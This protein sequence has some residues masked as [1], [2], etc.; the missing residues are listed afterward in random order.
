MFIEAQDLQLSHPQ[1]TDTD[2]SVFAGDSCIEIEPES[3]VNLEDPSKRRE[4][5]I[6]NDS[7]KQF[8]AYQD[9]K[10]LR[11][12]SDSSSKESKAESGS[13]NTSN[14]GSNYV[15]TSSL[16]S[17]SLEG[18][19]E[20]PA[21]KRKDSAGPSCGNIDADINYEISPESTL[22]KASVDISEYPTN[23]PKFQPGCSLSM[24]KSLKMTTTRGID[25]CIFKKQ[26]NRPPSVNGGIC[27]NST[28][29]VVRLDSL[30]PNDRLYN[31]Q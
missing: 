28:R 23:E 13:Y 7:T 20:L 3:D 31:T 16:Y 29:R 4:N 8:V 26:N 21:I 15:Q 24:F 11:N 2:S 18:S 9:E 14:P 25:H 19:F 17:T 30:K 22:R 12:R 6:T 10:H 1:P 27:V 5:V